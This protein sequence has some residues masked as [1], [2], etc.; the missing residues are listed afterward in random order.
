MCSDQDGKA[1]LLF[2]PATTAWLCLRTYVDSATCIFS[3]DKTGPGYFL[4]TF[5]LRSILDGNVVTVFVI[6]YNEDT[7]IL[8]FSSRFLFR[9]INSLSM[10]TSLQHEIMELLSGIMCVSYIL[11]L[12]FDG[13]HN[14]T[15]HFFVRNLSGPPSLAG[16]KGVGRATLG[17]SRFA[18]SQ[19]IYTAD[20]IQYTDLF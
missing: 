5:R 10:F 1:L 8:I 17:V 19:Y 4:G 16:G 18:P 20:A 9:T 7:T 14:H 2:Y 15:P 6:M 3:R 11:L 12:F 13:T